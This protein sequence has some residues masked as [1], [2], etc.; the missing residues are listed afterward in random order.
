M[1]AAFC[2]VVISWVSRPGRAQAWLLSLLAA[3]I[4]LV[5]ARASE[6]AHPASLNKHGAMGAWFAAI[7][8]GY[9]I[10]KLIGTSPAGTM[11]TVTCGGLRHRALLPRNAR[12]QPVAGVR[13]QLA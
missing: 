4:L 1:V 8:A 2:G 6:P 3:A 11:R 5:P 9:A 10:D 13:H 7:A 12:G